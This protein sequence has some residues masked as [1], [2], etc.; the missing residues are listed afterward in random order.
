MKTIKVLAILSVMALG[1]N[2]CTKE[3]PSGQG[4]NPFSNPG[5]DVTTTDPDPGLPV[6]DVPADFTKKAVVEK[7]T[8]EWCGYCPAG[9]TVLDGIMAANPNKVVGIAVHGANGDPFEIPYH[10]WI[11]S[12][13]SSGG[14]PTASIDRADRISRGAW[15]GAVSTSLAKTADCGL[16]MVAEENGGLLDLDVYVGYNSPIS[17]NTKLTILLTENEVP[18]SSPGA[19][20]GASSGYI[21]QHLLRGVLTDL[22]GDAIELNSSDNYTKVSFAGIDLNG[23][24]ILDMNNV[25]IAAILNVE[26]GASTDNGNDV[27]NAQESSL[28]EVKK[29]D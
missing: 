8:G 14:Y 5:G 27:L 29:W 1:M 13:T 21:H 24:G 25:H 26:G 16:A 20:S 23:M 28:N 22:P 15:P 7:I 6:G 19:Q 17:S 11:K 18:E 3:A 2:S 10:N 12:Q 4:T 9:A